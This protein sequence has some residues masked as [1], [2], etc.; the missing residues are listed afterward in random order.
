V[1][2]APEDARA[3]YQLALALRKS[4]SVAE[5]RREMAEARRLAPYLED[6][7]K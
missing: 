6:P 7:G 1:R 4:G 2:L 3:R 5:A